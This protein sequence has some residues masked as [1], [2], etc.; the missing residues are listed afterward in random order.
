MYK[1]ELAS[2]YR[3]NKLSETSND[4]AATLILLKEVKIEPSNNLIV[5]GFPGIP[6]LCLRGLEEFKSL[7]NGEETSFP[8]FKEGENLVI[9]ACSLQ[10]SSNIT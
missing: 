7:T 8:L 3:F 6:P 1:G 10:I 5:T 9:N 2:L 4:P